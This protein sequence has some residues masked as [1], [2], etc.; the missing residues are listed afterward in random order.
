MWEFVNDLLHRGW[1][2]ALA[3]GS[4]TGISVLWL[5]FGVL[6]LGFL[7]TVG[8]E[9]LTGGRNM[10]ALLA[11]L[12]SWKSCVGA[13]LALFVGW[14]IL[15]VYSTLHVAYR[16]HQH[17]VAAA[18]K[19]CISTQAQTSTN[20]HSGG[21]QHS[22]G[23]PNIE[24]KA[25]VKQGGNGDCQA[26]AVGGNASVE[27]C[28]S[29]PPPLEIKWSVREH[30]GGN[31]NWKFEKI[32]T[33]TPN[34]EWHPISLAVFCDQEVKDGMPEGAFMGL[35]KGFDSTK[36]TIFLYYPNPPQAAT[37]PLS[38]EVFSDREFKVIDVKLAAPPSGGEQ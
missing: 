10:A 19:P 11:A 36:R 31:A 17:F 22:K 15:L 12:K 6:V 1:H 7:F 30:E 16:D 2:E 14:V 28:N 8:I 13:A 25:P 34:V 38:F 20:P 5:G 23:P 27:G 26:N 4:S 32:V 18:A 9:W 3:N 29:G 35:Q 24:I 21:P 37:I 33:V